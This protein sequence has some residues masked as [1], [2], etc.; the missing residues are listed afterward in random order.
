MP[1]F[2]HQLSYTSSGWTRILQN[3]ADRFETVRIPIET[4][5]GKVIVAFFALDSYDVLLLSDLPDGVCT[6]TIDIALFSA[7]DVAHVHS[8]R[9]LSAAQVLDVV[10]NAGHSGSAMLKALAAVGG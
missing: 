5:G 1:Y 10:R 2:C 9:L 7:G 6:G 8:A 3:T 4:L